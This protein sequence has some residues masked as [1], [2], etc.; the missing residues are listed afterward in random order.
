MLSVELMNAV[1]VYQRQT[2]IINFALR[3]ITKKSA[4]TLKINLSLFWYIKAYKQVNASS[5]WTGS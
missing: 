2:K 5:T 4:L 1:N 3:N